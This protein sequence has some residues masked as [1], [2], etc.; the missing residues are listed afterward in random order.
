[1]KDQG[2]LNRFHYVSRDTTHWIPTLEWETESG[3]VQATPPPMPGTIRRDETGGQ[4]SRRQGPTATA[5]SAPPVEAVEFQ[6]DEAVPLVMVDPALDNFVLIPFPVSVLL[7]MHFITFGSYSFFRIT[8][9]HAK[10]PKRFPNDLTEGRAIGFLLVPFFNLY[11]VFVV[12]YRLCVR[13]N[14]LLAKYGLRG[15]LSSALAVT[16]CGF[17]V[18]PAL[19]AMAGSVVLLLLWMKEFEEFKEAILIFFEIPLIFVV[20]DLFLVIPLFA[21]LVQGSVNRLGHAQI[22]RLLAK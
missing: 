9:L 21:A 1:M 14:E 7:F 17:L 4:P 15:W 8:G 19:M 10:L 6:P 22:A 13:I 3:S 20:F 11:W 5:R 18:G 12:Y 2:T 16:M